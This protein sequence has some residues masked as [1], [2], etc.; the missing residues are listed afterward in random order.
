MK[1]PLQTAKTPYEILGVEEDAE[2]SAVNKAFKDRLLSGDNIAE[3]NNARNTLSRPNQRAFADIFLYDD[4]FLNQ[5]KP[6]ASNSALTG[7]R[8]N[9]KEAWGNI[10]S[11][12]FP[13]KAYLHSMAVLSY[14][15]A[16]NSE[17]KKLGGGDLCNTAADPPGDT[18][19]WMDTIGY[20]SVLITNTDM[21]RSWA[22][23]RAGIDLNVL[24]GDI[25]THFK[26]LFYNYGERYKKEGREEDAKR[27]QSY[28]LKF[29]TEVNAGRSLYKLK[30]RISR[31]DDSFYAC[32]GRIFLKSIGL[33]DLAIAEIEKG[34]NH[35]NSGFV[36]NI[37][38]LMAEIKDESKKESAVEKAKAVLMNLSEFGEIAYLM[39]EKKFDDAL[40][41]LESLPDERKSEGKVVKLFSQNYFEKGKIEFNANK[42]DLAFDLWMM[43]L[44]EAG[45]R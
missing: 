22:S 11:K 42:F 23:R 2:Q 30:I 17:E 12:L 29:L 40:E 39:M 41:W 13:N 3:I 35:I 28:G 27:F 20:W 18:D 31:R 21:L 19:L 8:S 16:V 10:L 33:F 24:S 45:G 4:T 37:T 14:W 5:M 32:G 44:R 15:W 26:N 36:V 25:E 38:P 1:D 34:E 9:T 7:G 43:A 6:S